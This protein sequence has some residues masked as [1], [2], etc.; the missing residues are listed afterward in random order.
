MTTQYLVWNENTLCYSEENSTMLGVLAGK[1][2]TGGR[3]W[4]N[5]PFIPAPTD[6][7][8]PATVKDFE[9][10]RVHPGGHLA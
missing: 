8:R 2:Q 4:I 6:S 5:G 7:L 10:F 3:D 9:Y 1:A